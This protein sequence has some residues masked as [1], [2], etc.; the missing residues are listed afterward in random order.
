ME[1]SVVFLILSVI[2][3]CCICGFLLGK[4]NIVGCS[5]CKEFFVS[6]IPNRLNNK[7]T[8]SPLSPDFNRDIMVKNNKHLGWK[9]YWK[10]RYSNYSV[11]QDQSFRGTI[12]ENYSDNNKLLY[13]GIKDISCGY[14]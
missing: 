12:Y 3:F 13:D 8:R 10:E 1:L 9:K 6:N 7:L 2:L 4:K 5:S 11:P 14:I